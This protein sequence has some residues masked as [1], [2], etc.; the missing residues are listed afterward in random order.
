MRRWFRGETSLRSALTH[1]GVPWMML[2]LSG[3]GVAAAGDQRLVDAVKQQ[4]TVLVHALLKQKVD[5]NT[6]QGDGATPLHWAAHWDNLE[7]ANLLIRAGANVNAANAYGVTPLSVACANGSAKMAATLLTA[8]ANPNIAR[9]TGETSLMTAARS[10]NADV[11][12]ALLAHGA[13]VNATEPFRRQSALMW[14]VSEKHSDAVRVLIEHGAD[15]RARSTSGFTSLMFAARQGDLESA[16][17]LLAAGANVNE[18][19]SDGTTALLVATVRGH[20]ALASYFLQHGADPNADKTGYT[21]LH[22]AVGSWET[23]LSGAPGIDTQR[24][25]EWAAL[26]GLPAGKVELVTALLAHGANPN[27]QL[28]KSPR[29]VGFG[30]RRLNNVGATPFWLAAAAA[31]ARLMR[32]L[33]ANGADPQLA[34]KDHTT[35]LMVAA[36]LGRSVVSMATESDA[37][38]AVKAVLEL[39]ADVNAANDAGDTAL[40]GAAQADAIRA[41]QLLIEKG[42][43]V[44]VQN[45]RGQTPL[46]IAEGARRRG[47]GGVATGTRTEDLLRRLVGSADAKSR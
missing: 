22:W 10:G 24:D 9:L 1:L 46:N 45:K 34:T 43:A 38:E 30:G 5:V 27:A 29:L 26:R 36:G 40:H 11:I 42:A 28:T 13:D 17:I 31:D 44:N 14:A 41:V 8:G 25:E 47:N 33:A 16:R 7:T 2:L 18:S 32:L 3:I 6:P 21:A 37:L 15:I 35:P 19:A 39:N 20:V 23:E 12:T 4:D